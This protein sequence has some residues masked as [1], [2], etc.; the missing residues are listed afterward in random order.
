[1]N[2][3]LHVFIQARRFYLFSSDRSGVDVSHKGVAERRFATGVV[4]SL[5]I[6]VNWYRH[7]LHLTAAAGGNVP[8]LC[9]MQRY[10]VC[11]VFF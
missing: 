8:V 3:R 2:W 6:A 10:R 5:R 4:L 7:R 9:S 1:M 11:S